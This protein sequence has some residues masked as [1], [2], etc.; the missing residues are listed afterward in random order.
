MGHFAAVF[1]FPFYDKENKINKIIMN[2]LTLTSF[3]MLK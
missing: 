3:S 2:Y 1:L